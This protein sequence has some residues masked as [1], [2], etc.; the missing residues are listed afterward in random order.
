M[1]NGGEKLSETGFG[2]RARRDPFLIALTNGWTD[3]H[4]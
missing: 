3:S 1:S 2:E 4:D